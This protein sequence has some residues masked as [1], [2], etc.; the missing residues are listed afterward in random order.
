MSSPC[1]ARRGRGRRI[2]LFAFGSLPAEWAGRPH[3]LALLPGA[4]TPSPAFATALPADPAAW[5]DA[6]FSRATQKKLRKKLR[7]LEAFGPPRH[8][9]ARGEAAKPLLAAFHAHKAAQAAARGERDVF[10]GRPCARCCRGC[11]TAA[12]WSSMR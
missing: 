5:L 9:C 4:P 2:D 12:R 11:S 3:P 8:V 7:K 6:H 10:A 1:C